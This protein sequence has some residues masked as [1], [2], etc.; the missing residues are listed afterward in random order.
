MA[1]ERHTALHIPEPPSRPDHEGH[2][3][4]YFSPAGPV[5]R[6][7]TDTSAAAMRDLAYA[8]IRVLDDQGAACGPWAP[9]LDADSLRG[10]LRAM[11]RTRAY[12]ARMMKLQ[13]QGLTSFY[14]QCTGEEAVA[15][16]FQTA[17]AKGDM[18]FPTYRQQGLLIAQDWPVIDMMCQ[19]LSNTKDRLNGRQSPVTRWASST[20][21]MRAK[22]SPKRSSTLSSRFSSVISTKTTSRSPS[23][24]ALRMAL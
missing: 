1:T 12:D 16:G 15:C 11:L 14:M 2:Y 13:R 19:V 4:L 23:A 7:E 5:A 18:N 17:L 22:A 24:A 10:G 9:G 6:P 3:D 20:C 21:G 8:L